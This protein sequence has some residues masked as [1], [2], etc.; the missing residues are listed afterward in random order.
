MHGR[1]VASDRDYRRHAVAPPLASSLSHH[2]SASFC[3]VSGFETSCPSHSNSLGF[4]AKHGTS[5]AGV[6]VAASG[7]GKL[8]TA[9]AYLARKK[10]VFLPYR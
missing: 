3:V 1:S 8:E 6:S 9:T 7:G 5:G 4:R 2:T 10:S